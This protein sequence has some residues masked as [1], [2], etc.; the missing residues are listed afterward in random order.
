[1]PRRATLVSRFILSHLIVKY[2]K[3]DNLL[4]GTNKFVWWYLS[5]VLLLT[6]MLWNTAAQTP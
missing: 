1:M 5:L 4:R 6:G 2:S 3:Y